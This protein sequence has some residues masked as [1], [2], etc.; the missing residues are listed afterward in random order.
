MLL[1][2]LECNERWLAAT[3]RDKAKTN[4]PAHPAIPASGPADEA[5]VAAGPRLPFRE[6]REFH[7]FD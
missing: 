1:V 2:Q 4:A 3:L 6:W 5:Y 7:G